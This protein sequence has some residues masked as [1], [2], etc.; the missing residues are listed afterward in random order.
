MMVNSLVDCICNSLF[1]IS[2]EYI[3]YVAENFIHFCFKK[4]MK[5]DGQQLG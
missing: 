4:K 1:S 5:V 2:V 3:C